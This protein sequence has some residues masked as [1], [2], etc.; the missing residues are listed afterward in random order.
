LGKKMKKR[1]GV[2][3]ERWGIDIVREKIKKVAKTPP[4]HFM[5]Y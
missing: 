3:F 5:P 2:S 1:G 4:G